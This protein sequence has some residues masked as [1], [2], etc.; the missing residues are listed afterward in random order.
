MMLAFLDRLRH[1]VVGP[2][3]GVMKM[4]DELWLQYAD[5][6]GH[7]TLITAKIDHKDCAP[8]VDGVPPMHYRLAY[9][10]A[11]ADNLPKVELRTSALAT[12]CDFVLEAIRACR[13]PF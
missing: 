9:T 1:D 5:G 2:R 13:G 6:N 12:A 8:L 10:L 11:E 4:S 7:R 3:L